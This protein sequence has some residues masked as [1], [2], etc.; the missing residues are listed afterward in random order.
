[1]PFVSLLLR[2][3]AELVKE[4]VCKPRSLADDLSI[5]AIGDGHARTLSG[6]LEAT[7]NFL[8]DM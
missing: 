2:P 5:L 4:H 3:W 8:A 7:R 1:M 6:A